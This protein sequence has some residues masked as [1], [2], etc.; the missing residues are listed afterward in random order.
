[1]VVVVDGVVVVRVVV[2]IGI[3]IRGTRD[4]V[5]QSGFWTD[6]KIAEETVQ[7]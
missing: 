1:M 4:F 5:G 2:G 6:A 3:I 7:T